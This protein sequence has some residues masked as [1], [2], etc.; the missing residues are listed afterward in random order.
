MLNLFFLLE[1]FVIKNPIKKNKTSIYGRHFGF[2]THTHT[3]KPAK[4]VC[5]R[6]QELQFTCFRVLDRCLYRCCSNLNCNLSLNCGNSSLPLVQPWLPVSLPL[7]L[8]LSPS[9]YLSCSGF[10]SAHLHSYC[11]HGREWHFLNRY[12]MDGMETVSAIV[13][14]MPWPRVLGVH[15]IT[16]KHKYLHPLYSSTNKR[17]A[18]K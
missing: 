11:V 3:Q 6:C 16:L 18:W 7:S 10:L 12:D 5:T 13:V 1:L 17:T 15:L 14:C 8:S 9:S 4:M 2:L